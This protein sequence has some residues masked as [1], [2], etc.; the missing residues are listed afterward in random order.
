MADKVLFFFLG[1][2]AAFCAGAFIR[3]ASRR[4]GEYREETGELETAPLFIEVSAV[5]ETGARDS[6]QDAYMTAGL[7]APDKGILAAVA[8]GM[9]GLVNSGQV[10]RAAAESLR[11]SFA[12]G[13]DIE[14]ERQLKILLAQAVNRVEQLLRGETARSGTTL[15]ACLIRDGTLSWISVGDSR[16]YLWRGGGLIQLTRDHSF[17]Y[18]LTLLALQGEMSLEEA[19]SDPRGE[20]LTSYIGGDFPAKIDWNREPVPLFPGDRVL[21]ASDGVYRALSQ[22]ELAGCLSGRACEAADRIKR[23]IAGKA[24]PRQDNFTAVILAAE[25]RKKS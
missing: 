8:D 15:A 5:H 12:P 6:Q 16:V 17:E 22:R 7:K 3:L 13:G 2:L 20:S 24:L 19:E 14:P 23:A 25:K 10:S 21:I 1:L 18:E 11:D 4:R 9:G